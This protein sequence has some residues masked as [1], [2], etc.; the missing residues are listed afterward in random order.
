MASVLIYIGVAWVVTH[1]GGMQRTLEPA[2]ARQFA[3]V[4]GLVWMASLAALP[5]FGQRLR[6][7]RSFGLIRLA[8]FESGALYGLVLTML[9]GDAKFTLAFGIC[10][11]MLMSA[12]APES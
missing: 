11:L 9:S 8:I 5:V 4:L 2:G 7:H 10:A 1:Q 3:I 6:E 12:T